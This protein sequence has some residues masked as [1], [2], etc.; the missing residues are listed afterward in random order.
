[1]TTADRQR[2]LQEE[3]AFAVRLL[4][5]YAGKWVAVRGQEL[6]A[7][8]E[9]AEQLY[10]QLTDETAPYRSFRVKRK[11]GVALLGFHRG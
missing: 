10:G 1:M 8:A 6:I 3:H 9:T 2:Q 7:E 11:S 4:D 5:E